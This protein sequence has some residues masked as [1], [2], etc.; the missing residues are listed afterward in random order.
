[1]ALREKGKMLRSRTYAVDELGGASDV[2]VRDNAVRME[3]DAAYMVSTYSSIRETME[4]VMG[5]IG[6]G[7]VMLQ[8][9]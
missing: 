5:T 8:V 2:T 9:I 6:M 3:E 7:E 4:G 1:M